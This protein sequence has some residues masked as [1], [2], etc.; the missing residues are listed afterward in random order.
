VNVPVACTENDVSGMLGTVSSPNTSRLVS[1][2]V[3]PTGSPD[4]SVVA[5]TWTRTP[6]CPSGA[7]SAAPASSGGVTSMLQPAACVISTRSPSRA[8]KASR[9]LVRWN[10]R[11]LADPPPMIC[12]RAA[13]GPMRAIDVSS[14]TASGS[15]GVSPTGALRSSTIASA[16]AWR[17]RRGARAGRSTPRPPGRRRTRRS[18]RRSTGRCPRARRGFLRPPARRGPRR[19]ALP[20]ETV[21][22]RGGGFSASL[23]RTAPAGPPIPG[24]TSAVRATDPRSDIIGYR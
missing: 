22:G 10:G 2:V 4:Q 11:R 3:V 16:D 17:P 8:A 9:G 12:A 5:N 21:P 24:A 18:A 23:S 15:S 20:S 19:P 7:T 1:R 14:S 6:C 13:F